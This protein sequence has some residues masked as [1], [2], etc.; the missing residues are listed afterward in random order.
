[1]AEIDAKQ[2]IAIAKS[3]LAEMFA[4][5]LTAKPTLE[6]IW[7]DEKTETW[8]ITLGVRR[9][10]NH[11]ERRDWN[12][13]MNGGRTVPDYKVARVSRKTGEVVSVL[14]RELVRV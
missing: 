8:C 11:V 5:E 10:T 6:E 2:A 4:D 1:M 7:L 3:H 12:V 14:N 9:P 13:L